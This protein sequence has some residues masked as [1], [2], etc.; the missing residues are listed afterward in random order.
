MPVLSV[1]L[2]F[3]FVFAQ[4][5]LVDDAP[6]CGHHDRYTYQALWDTLAAAGCTIDFTTDVGRYPDLSSYDFVVLM[7]HNS[8]CGGY[9]ESQRTQL[10]DFVCSGGQVLI[11]P[12]D[13]LS[14]HNELLSDPRWNTGIQLVPGGSP[15]RTT[16]IASFPPLTD[17]ISY[18]DWLVDAE[19]LVNPPAY[20]FVW[21]DACERVLAAVSYP[22][23]LGGF[24]CNT[25]ESGGRI[26]VIGENHT[27]EYEVVGYVEPMSYRFIVNILT[28]LAGVGDTLNPC[29]PPEGIPR[30]DSIPCADPGDVAHLYGENIPPDAD[31][32]FD[33]SPISFTWI[34][35][36]HV[37]FTV[38]LSAAQG[39]HIVTVQVTGAAGV[40]SFNIP[41]Q[42]Y[43]D[44]LELLVFVP[45]CADIGDTVWFYGENFS[46][47]ATITMGGAPVSTYD[48]VSDTSGWFVVPDTAGLV[49]Y[50]SIGQSFRYQ[51]CIEN[52]P[53]QIDCA[54]MLVP[55][56][57]PPESEV[58]ARIEDI[59]FGERTDGT[60]TVYIIY[61]LVA[62]SPQNVVLWCSSDGGA[63][64][65]VPCTTVYGAVGSGVAPG[66]SLVIVWAAGED[67][68]S[69][70]HSNWVFRV[71]L[72]D[73]GGSGPGSFGSAPSDTFHPPAVFSTGDTFWCTSRITGEAAG[74]YLGNSVSTAGDVNGDGYDD[75][76]MGAYRSSAGRAYI[77]FGGPEFS[78][79]FSAS[80]ADIII[81]GE[82]ADDHLG[83]SVSTAGDVNGDGYD[84]IIV[85]AE[86]NDAGGD[87]AG[88]A[89]IFFGGPG[90][91]G[92]FNASSADVVITG[93]AADD[94]LG[95]SVST[96]GDINGDGYDDI[97]VGAWHNDTGGSNAGRAYIFFGGPG[98]SGSFNASSADVIITGEAANDHLG[99]SVSTAGDVNGDGYDDIIVGA[100]YNGAGGAWAGRAYIFF[101]GPGFSGSFNA[102]AADI[103]ITGEAMDNQL[104]ISVSTAGD[105]NSDGYDDIVVGAHGNSVGGT[106]AGRA[107]V[108]WGSPGFSGSFSASSAD[109]IIT[110]E[111]ANDW[112][113]YSVSTAGDINGDG[114]DDII[115]GAYLNDAGG[116][117]VGRAY[118]FHG[119]PGFSGS[120]NASSANIIITGEA[121]DDLLGFSVSTAGNVNSDGCDDIIVGAWRNDA[122]GTDAGRAYVY[123]FTVSCPFGAVY[124]S[125][126]SD[127]GPVDTWCP[128]V[129]A[130]CPPGGEVGEATTITW[131]V[132]DSFI[133]PNTLA[134]PYP[135]ELWFSPDGGASWSFIGASANTGS[136][137]WAYPPV[138]T[139]SALIMVCATD[140]FGHTCCD[141]CGPFS[142]TGDTVSP[143]GYAYADTCSPDSVVFVLH[144]D[145]GIDWS[146]VCIQDPLGVLCYPDSMR[147]VCDT[148]LIFYPRLPDSIADP[149]RYFY[150][151]LWS[152][153]D[154]SGNDLPE[155]LVDDSL[156]VRFRHPCCYPAVVWLVCPPEGFDFWSSC[157]AQTVTFGVV[158]TSG[159]EID[160]TRIFVRRIVDG[161][162]DTVPPDS[163]SFS[164]SGDTLWV[165]VPGAYSDLDSVWVVLDSLFTTVG[166]KTEP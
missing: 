111:A 91:S 82:A 129:T 26:I 52:E 55:C 149:S 73:S 83:C 114:Y 93:E 100:H 151:R 66:E 160:T 25:C 155:T 104:G 15:T 152:A 40:I 33:G 34:D 166:C 69:N 17:G 8:P 32:L 77:F 95:R 60:D 106:A 20:P 110:G 36:T 157:A 98:F 165:I 70:E 121:A 22:Q 45:Y 139:G 85:G 61:D 127:P 158:D 6:F 80:S 72:A 128:R 23:G 27:Y 163:L 35:S 134:P 67:V 7:H 62:D 48:I 137:N 112:L 123:A 164:H 79:S 56:P 92:L 103:I 99:C 130:T 131:T 13:D 153:Q 31:L 133:P 159:Q 46:P 126:E 150:V 154:S 88:R 109:I 120:F 143:W 29:E 135:I 124:A 144:D 147:V 116:S 97:I 63:S 37:T 11:M 16:C 101:G 14:P 90:F 125:A 146:S 108:F 118:V 89:Y 84:D 107:Y 75:I 132:E 1:L 94:E 87:R 42:V 43:C 119:G 30:L 54:W 140:S 71:E 86:D 142:I 162:E 65:D 76:I 64:W 105:V 68:P 9:T 96:A 53:T 161:A 145:A 21:D 138:L 141:T 47:S 2:L 81:V 156:T 10:I 148:M 102:S 50:P 49:G 19:L 58:V 59:R 3:S 78:G 57:C 28:S 115:V 74:D 12:M 4:H 39:F 113:G 41:I 122:G 136:F 18:L 5:V 24:E 44:W 117:D 38:P 51:V